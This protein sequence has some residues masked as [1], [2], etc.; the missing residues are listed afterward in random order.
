MNE[1]IQLRRPM[2]DNGPDNIVALHGSLS[3]G[4]Q[5]AKLIEACGRKY[6]VVA[7]DL[8]G[9]GSNSLCLE[10]APSRLDTEAEYLSEKL[11]ALA[12]PIHLVGH[13]FGGSIAFKLATSGRYAH[14]VRSL[15][16]IEPVLPSILFELDADRPYYELFAHECVRVCT[17]LWRGQ[18]RLALQRFL[19]FWNGRRS[20]DILPPNTRV[21]ML[22]RVN[23]VGGDFSAAFEEMGVGEAARRLTVP[24]LL[25]S[26][27]NSP[28]PAQQIV[29]RL[30]SAIPN[31]RHVHMPEAGH[32]L[33][34][35]HAAKLNPTIL[36]HVDM[37]QAQS[38]TAL[39]LMAALGTAFAQ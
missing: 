17:P 34:V 9:Y 36:Q 22:E 15:T 12:G 13:S 33:C 23:K 14:R 1:L 8:E 4:Q 28:L 21:A 19:T 39:H 25:L 32:M 7:P 5:W 18:K 16:L 27:G 2:N 29:K 6:H 26:G 35:T 30:T 10:P 11:E 38:G 3:S 31:A 20:W 37:A 24:T